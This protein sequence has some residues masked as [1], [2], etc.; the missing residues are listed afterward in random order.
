MMI[1]LLSFAQNEES[2]S[3]KKQTTFEKFTSTIGHIVKF[4]DY[5]MS[6][7][8]GKI[9]SGML[10]TNYTV[11]AEIRQVMIGNETSLFLRLTYQG[12]G[13]SERVAFIAYEDVVEINKALTE[14][15]SQSSTDSTGDAYYLENKF[16]T[17]DNFY[18]GYY[19]Q[20]NVSKKGEES[21]E[22]KWYVNLDDRYNHSTAF[23]SNPDGLKSLFSL[24]IQKMTELK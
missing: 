2:V 20:K 23:F 12:S 13:Y 10:A 1:P 5:K 24:A 11:H 19:I 22:L 3:E 21:N 17:K 9:G 6:D 14:L 18:I 16:K 15:I 7:V 4:K 8:S